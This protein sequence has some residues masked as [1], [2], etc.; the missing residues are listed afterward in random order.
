MAM[1][2]LG[3][4]ARIALM[5]C[6]WRGVEMAS[7]STA[8]P[9]ALGLSVPEA[10]TGPPMEGL[11]GLLA[12]MAG[13][14]QAALS[15]MY[16]E[17]VGQVFAIARAVL[18]SKED[19]EEVVCDVYCHV[20]QRAGTYDAARGGVMGWLAVIA[21][22]KAIDRLRQ[23]RMHLSLDDEHQHGIAG[24][25]AGEAAGP[26]EFLALLQSG[27]AIRRAL[28]SLTPQ[29]RHLLSMAFFQDLTHREIADA[30]GMPLGTVKSHVRRALGALQCELAA[31]R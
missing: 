27:S 3:P 12:R 25:L 8:G 18:R 21:R 30:L 28:G 22:N 9:G 1:N 19:A 20:W 26:E 6:R 16:E 2:L 29:R 13:G 31:S 23:R 24:S 11:E 17:T 4:P 15:A 14:E 7:S 10:L 5:S